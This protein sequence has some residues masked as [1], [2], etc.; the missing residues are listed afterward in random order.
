M[1]DLL[2]MFKE[3]A[4]ELIS[5][6]DRKGGLRATIESLRRQM[7]ESDRRRA[8]ARA[9]AEL[10][11]LQRQIDE[12]IAAIGIQAVGLYETGELASPELQP[13]CQYI[14]QLKAL[15]AQQES[16]LAKLEAATA[17]R[18]IS[19]A[20]LCAACGKNLPKEAAFCPHCGTATASAIKRFCIHCGAE[21][22]AEAKFCTRCGQ[23][24]KE[25]Y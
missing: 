5:A 16:E 7:A 11:Q 8:I 3:K 9:K 10:G 14:V 18:S 12:M 2:T 22:R 24:R 1:A 4:E 6:V 20:R 19:E 21:L 25:L 15:L 17:E 13:L 23:A